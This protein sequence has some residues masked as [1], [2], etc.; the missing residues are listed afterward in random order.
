MAEQGFFAEQ[1][2]VVR[3]VQPRGTH[4]W[5]GGNVALDGRFIGF[6]QQFPRGVKLEAGVVLRPLAFGRSGGNRLI[7][8]G[9]DVLVF[10]DNAV[11]RFT[12]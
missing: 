11:L 12:I 10:G 1:R 8:Q 5:H 7:F 3:A 4:S 6:G 2:G 9:G